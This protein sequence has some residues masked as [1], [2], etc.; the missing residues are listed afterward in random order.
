MSKSSEHCCWLR[1]Y[2]DLCKSGAEPWDRQTAAPGM[3]AA[4]GAGV[5]AGRT[6]AEVLASAAV[7]VQVGN[8][9]VPF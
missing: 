2:T 1:I 9:P 4:A 8:T 7:Q 6:A 5:W 3:Q